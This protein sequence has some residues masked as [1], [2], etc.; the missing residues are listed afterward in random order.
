M[1]LDREGKRL[2]HAQATPTSR[3]RASRAS[4]GSRRPRRSRSARRSS[5]RL[6]LLL[7]GA[8]TRAHRLPYIDEPAFQWYPAF[9]ALGEPL[10]HPDP[11]PA[12]QL[13]RTVLAALDWPTQRVHLFGFGQGGTAALE[14]ALALSAPLGS[15]VA[16]SGPLLSFPATPTHRATPVLALGP[17]QPALH[18]AFDSVRVQRAPPGERMPASRGEWEPVMRFWSE[19]LARRQGEGLYEVLSGMGSPA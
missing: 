18:R 4:S 19:R 17:P 13:L 2:K 9:D 14:L 3:S 1:S 11:T 12:V 7:R 5:A 15:A 10:A 6:P 16:V 8:L